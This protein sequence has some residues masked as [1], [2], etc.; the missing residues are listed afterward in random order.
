M[1]LLTSLVHCG[2]KI[3][4]SASALIRLWYVKSSMSSNFDG[5]RRQDK[6]TYSKIILITQVQLLTLNKA[7]YWVA[8]T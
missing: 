1:A 2:N 4:E 5:H 6:L 8:P 7:K 3:Y